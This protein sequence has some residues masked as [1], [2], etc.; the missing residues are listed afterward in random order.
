VALFKAFESFKN[1][2]ATAGIVTLLSP[3][4][5]IAPVSAQETIPLNENLSFVRQCRRVNRTIEVFSN[6]TLSPASSRVGTFTAGTQITLTGVLREGRAQVY[7]P[8]TNNL[9]RVIGWVDAGALG[10]CGDDPVVTDLCYRADVALIVRDQPTTTS[11]IVSSYTSG[12]I[13]Y[14]TT[15]PPTEQTSPGGSPN[16]GRVWLEVQPSPSVDGWISRT[17][18]GGIGSN[19]TPLPS[20]Q[21]R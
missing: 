9:I 15:N 19:I 17:G 14:P 16:F 20:A 1:L 3:F 5:A 4:V 2:I 18:T 8:T 13:I 11:A 6:S 7:L 12:E 21:C 10:P